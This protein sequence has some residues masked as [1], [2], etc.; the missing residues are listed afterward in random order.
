MKRFLPICL[1]LFICCLLAITLPSL[2]LAAPSTGTH[3]FHFHY[4]AFPLIPPNQPITI[5]LFVNEIINSD[6]SPNLNELNDL[7]QH[8]SSRSGINIIRI[9]GEKQGSTYQRINNSAQIK[10]LAQTLNDHLTGNFY[11]VFGNEVNNPTEWGGQA[12]PA[13]YARAYIHFY[14]SVPDHNKIKVAP[15][16]LDPLHSSSAI[17]FINQARTA[18]D[19]ADAYAFNVYHV[20]GK[21]GQITN[22]SYLSYLWLSQQVGLSGNKPLLLTEFSLKPP[23]NDQNLSEVAEFITQTVDKL[24][25]NV[26]AVTPLIRNPCSSLGSNAYFL[27]IHPN[28]IL[29]LDGINVTP[30]SCDQIPGP[31]KTTISSP[32]L[33]CADLDLEKSKEGSAPAEGLEKFFQRTVEGSVELTKA[34]FPKFKHFQERMVTGLTKL[35]PSELGQTLS[36]PGDSTLYFKHI[37]LTIDESGTPVLT[38]EDCN[39]LPRGTDKLPAN[40]WGRL[41]ALRGL[42][43]FLGEGVCQPVAEFQFKLAGEGYP[44]CDNLRKCSGERAVEDTS[45]PN[46]DPPEETRFSFL[47]WIKRIIK[48][49]IEEIIALFTETETVLV[50]S[51][52]RLPGGSELVQN[53][54]ILRYSLPQEIIDGTKSLGAVSSQ[55]LKNPFN[56]KFSL[57]PEE[58]KE[59]DGRYYGLESMWKNYCLDLCSRLPPGTIHQFGDEICPSCNPKDYQPSIE[60][61]ELDMS[62]C[63]NPSPTGCDYYDP[64]ATEGCGPN[65]DPVCESGLCN[66]FEISMRKDYAHSDCTPPF[67]GECNNPAL[68]VKANFSPNPE[69]G[70]GKCRYKN[71]TVCVR[72]DRVE[73]NSCAA[74]CNWQCCSY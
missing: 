22:D 6:N 47:G 13:G 62:L 60:D 74:V 53:S 21:E 8:L 66:P 17:S 2:V 67:E 41:A 40:L 51:R 1:S 30:L 54:K 29:N 12:D 57:S 34:N 3:T 31:G 72:A 46:P 33:I 61:I 10:A 71:A 65:Q 58:E 43:G 68:C 20:K 64:N 24:T 36:L 28:R 14:Q 26:V 49:T 44:S 32:S 73:V 4:K 39:S 69:G 56:Y 48:G 27:Y 38:D 18:W 19:M 55:A 45:L 52:S 11:V 70:Y 16:A 42:C 59:E 37:P 5:M 9:A 35:L 15:A 23:E 63:Q 7:N 50:Y 25:G